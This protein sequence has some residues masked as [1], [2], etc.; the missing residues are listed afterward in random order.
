MT[1]YRDMFPQ[2]L[3]LFLLWS[4]LL[5]CSLV[6]LV[7]NIIVRDLSLVGWMLVC[8]MWFGYWSVRFAVLAVAD[9]GAPR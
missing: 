7:K 8:V 4:T 2:S 6:L 5:A 3:A 9:H 1:G